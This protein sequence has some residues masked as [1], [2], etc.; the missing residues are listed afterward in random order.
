MRELSGPWSRTLKPS[1]QSPPRQRLVVG[2]RVL[3]LLGR[4]QVPLVDQAAVGQLLESRLDASP[5]V[6][7]QQIAPGVVVADVGRPAVGG[8][9]GGPMKATPAF[10]GRR[11]TQVR[12]MPA[13]PWRPVR[14]V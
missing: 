9:D 14:S 2:G 13:P 6:E 5:A 10:A 7:R 4:V 3:Q 1:W 12:S 11:R 8:R